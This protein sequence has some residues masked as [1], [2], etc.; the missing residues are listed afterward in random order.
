MLE[1]KIDFTRNTHWVLVMCNNISPECSAH[2]GLSSRENIVVSFTYPSLNG[3]DVFVAGTRK[4]CQQ[5]LALKKHRIA[6]SPE[7]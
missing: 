1:T 2:A 5:V 3:I 6:R 7:I 4:M